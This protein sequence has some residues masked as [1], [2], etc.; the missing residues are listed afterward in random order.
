M[1][2]PWRHPPPRRRRPQTHLVVDTTD[3]ALRLCLVFPCS[4]R[5]AAPSAAGAHLSRLYYT[6]RRVKLRLLHL[7]AH[8]NHA[9]VSAGSSVCRCVCSNADR[10]RWI[11]Q[12]CATQRCDAR[13]ARSACG[14]S[15]RRSWSRLRRH[16]GRCKSTA[17]PGWRHMG[18]VAHRP[19]GIGSW[20]LT[21]Q[22]MRAVSS[23]ADKDRFRSET[24]DR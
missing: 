20:S 8:R 14:W 11:G 2:Q 15:P 9:A 13:I 6:S 21:L 17:S 12:G 23:P 18:D 19:M 1:L 5:G 3:L 16:P 4:H 10:R 7:P 22:Q 24:V